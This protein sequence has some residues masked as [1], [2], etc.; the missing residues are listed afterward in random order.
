MAARDS[1]AE[2]VFKQSRYDRCDSSPRRRPSSRRCDASNRWTCNDRP[3]RPIATNSS[4]KSGCWLS[5]SE[6]SS[7]MMKS[8]GS[9]ERDAP[10]AR[11]RSYSVTFA[12]LP[13]ARSSS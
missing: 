5:S 3:R 10:A 7:T 12:K 13:A 4:A 1:L 6:N 11:A 9:G 8:A 2:K